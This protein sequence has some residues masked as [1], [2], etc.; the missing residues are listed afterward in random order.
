MGEAKRRGQTGNG[1]YAMVV[2]P[3]E[4][5]RLKEIAWRHH[6]A[7]T[8]EMAAVFPEREFFTR[9]LALAYLFAKTMTPDDSEQQAAQADNL[10]RMM[11]WLQLPWRL[12]PTEDG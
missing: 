11:D 3:E 2:E 6:A 5:M 9:A 4:F 7:L 8:T 12:V 10:N 1:D